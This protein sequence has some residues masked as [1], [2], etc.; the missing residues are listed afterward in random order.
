[1]PRLSA[2]VHEIFNSSH[3]SAMMEESPRVTETGASRVK[4]SRSLPCSN[5]SP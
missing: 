2:E 1:M 4:Y 3:G 5:G